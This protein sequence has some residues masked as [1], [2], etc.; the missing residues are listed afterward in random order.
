MVENAYAALSG[1]G[2]NR[3]SVAR[4]AP[5]SK[6][7]SEDQSEETPF[8]S[9]ERAPAALPSALIEQ[10]LAMHRARTVGGDVGL[11]AASIYA[12]AGSGSSSDEDLALS[13]SDIDYGS[14]PS[15]SGDAADLRDRLKNA[16]KESATLKNKNAEQAREIAKFQERAELASDPDLDLTKMRV[17]VADL[18]RLRDAKEKELLERN[19]ELAGLKAK[20]PELT[21]GGESATASDKSETGFAEIEQQLRAE[22]QRIADVRDEQQAALRDKDSEN[23]GLA[24]RV[25]QL[26]ENLVAQRQLTESSGSEK[27]QLWAELTEK[28]EQ[29]EN[30]AGRVVELGLSL[31]N[32]QGDDNTRSEEFAKISAERDR[33]AVEL[34]ELKSAWEKLATERDRLAGE[35]DA[36]RVHLA[37]LQ[38]EG[39]S[40]KEIDQEL[41]ASKEEL[42]SV[43]AEWQQLFDTQEEIAAKSRSRIEELEARLQ[44]AGKKGDDREKTLEAEL[45]ELRQEHERVAT[46]FDAARQRIE[47]LSEQASALSADESDAAAKIEEYRQ[48]ATDKDQCISRLEIE[49]ETLRASLGDIE[50]LAEQRRAHIAELSAG[51]EYSESQTARDRQ[52]TE[53]LRAELDAVRAELG[54]ETAARDRIQEIQAE[55]D[56]AREQL[57]KLESER[58]V[59][60]EALNERRAEVET[61]REALSKEQAKLAVAQERAKMERQAI[62]DEL[63]AADA[64]ARA[65]LEE[66]DAKKTEAQARH[67]AEKERLEQVLADA[68]TAEERVVRARDTVSEAGEQW[69]KAE[70]D[71]RK[72]QR[73]LAGLRRKVVRRRKLLEK[74][75]TIK[76][77]EK[78]LERKVAEAQNILRAAEEHKPG[79]KAPVVPRPW[80]VEKAVSEHQE[81]VEETRKARLELQEKRAE[82]QRIDESLREGRGPSESENAAADR[83]A[84]A[85]ALVR[86]VEAERVADAAELEKRGL[87]ETIREL[88]KKAA[89]VAPE[90]TGKFPA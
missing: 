48:Q 68:R 14:H 43:R 29:A 64:E 45:D 73:L 60:T 46:E 53:K 63:T 54:D 86:A 12:R 28:T 38:A 41:R 22:I 76:G 10:A 70:A 72:E 18:K 30:L 36:T 25:K 7:S 34:A 20:L 87:I 9:G 74:L 42:E 16:I 85:D 19:A 6:K 78:E 55:Q 82:W 21:E 75:K 83:A 35:R 71:T 44:L 24:A 59:L 51:I 61:E 52:Q 40:V 15:E 4:R 39:A 31:S 8:S 17:R 84:L 47:E 49:R 50:T 79:R 89:K 32:L 57:S 88:K 37:A 33:H 67:D 56:Q 11:A 62:A 13:S 3:N 23:A 5:L 27:K 69:T 1:A 77:R 66:L 90:I 58:G 81:L 26:E 2:T 80:D 65:A